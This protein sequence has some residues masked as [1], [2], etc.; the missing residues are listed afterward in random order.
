MA[1]R[2]SAHPGGFIKRNYLDEL[3]I[4][5]AQLAEALGIN[6]A[7]LSRL[8]NE[9]SD[10]SPQLAMRI[11]KVLGGSPGS[12]LNMQANHS[13][14]TL[15]ARTDTKADAWVPTLVLK[16]GKL[17]EQTTAKKSKASTKAVSKRKTPARQSAVA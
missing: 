14:A 3:D 13:L 16:K 10:L 7:T 5:A 11:S 17:A 6:K 12:W 9:K 1:K 2:I 4:T 15:E 8:L